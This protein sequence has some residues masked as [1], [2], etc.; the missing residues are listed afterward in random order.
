MNLVFRTLRE[1]LFFSSHSLSQFLFIFYSASALR[2][3]GCGG[4]CFLCVPQYQSL[5]CDMQITKTVVNGTDST[6][7]GTTVL[8]RVIQECWP[9]LP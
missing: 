3:S 8:V 2:H 5:F 1:L 4:R 9:I 7:I 6:Y